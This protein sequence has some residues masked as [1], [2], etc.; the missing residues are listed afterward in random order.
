M[1]EDLVRDLDALR[2][3]DTLIGRAYV[4]AT[5]RRY[6]L[7]ALAGLIAGFGFGLANIA[8]F[9]ALQAIW[10]SIWAATIGAVADF[11]IALLVL[12]AGRHAGSAELERSL[13]LRSEAIAAI[14]ADVRDVRDGFDALGEDVAAV[15]ESIAA[16]VHNPLDT[17]V[18]E[19]LVP[20][21]LSI[22]AALK[23]KKD[24]DQA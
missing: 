8:G 18:R 3:A 19:L 4:A 13:E 22:I 10:G 24:A 15:R 16:F 1:I 5:T 9:L 20:A 7:L 2:R 14:T 6:S 12:L 23:A 11:L 21:A 17:A